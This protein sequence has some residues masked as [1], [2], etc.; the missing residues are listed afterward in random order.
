MDG[1][2]EGRKA[3]NIVVIGLVCVRVGVTLI[4]VI[5]LVCVRVGVTLS[6]LTHANDQQK[7]E[8]HEPAGACGMLRAVWRI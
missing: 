8:G 5:G 2:K 6:F 7:K 3:H 1:I 4:V